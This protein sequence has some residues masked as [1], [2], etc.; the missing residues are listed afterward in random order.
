MAYRMRMSLELTGL[1]SPTAG[2]RPTLPILPSPFKRSN[3]PPFTGNDFIDKCLS[4]DHIIIIASFL[5][6]Q[7]MNALSKTNKTVRRRLFHY[8]EQMGEAMPHHKV[9]FIGGRN[10]DVKN[11]D[12]VTVY[13]CVTT[14]WVQ[15]P[16]MPLRRLESSACVVG[17]VLYVF[18]GYYENKISE[19]M[20]IDD[21]VEQGTAPPYA[22]DERSFVSGSVIIRIRGGV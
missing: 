8:E 7:G 14:Q 20:K 5:H 18:G 9:F 6:R 2:D 11:V 10:R 21:E 4:H 22:E 12:K 13:D 1:D 15:T 3:T 17:D 16:A 19:Q